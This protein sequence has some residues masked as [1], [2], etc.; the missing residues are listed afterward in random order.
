MNKVTLFYI[1]GMLLLVVLALP[2]R[3]FL[4]ND[5]LFAAGTVAYLVLL[6]VMVGVFAKRA[7]DKRRHV[8]EE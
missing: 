1:G 4:Q 2:V 3:R 5:A 7:R 8:K 6:R